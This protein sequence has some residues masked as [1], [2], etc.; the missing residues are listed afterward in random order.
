ML[1]IP[2]G[3]KPDLQHFPY[4]TVILV[5]LNCLVFFGFQLKEQQAA[6]QAGA[7]Y[8]QQGLQDIECP[9]YLTYLNQ[10]GQA[11]KAGK[12]AAML[13]KKDV[14]ILAVMQND[15]DYLKAMHGDQIVKENEQV[16]YDWK[17][18][19]A[20]FELRL[21][22]RFTD[23]YAL[24]SRELKP[25]TFLS[26]MFMHANTG[27]LLGNMLVLLLV[28]YIV[29]DVLGG[30]RFLCFYLISGAGAGA[31]FIAASTGHDAGLLGASGAIAGVMGMYAALFGFRKIEFFYWILIYC[32]LARLPAIVLLPVWLANEIYQKLTT[33]DSNVAY[34]AHVG[35]LLVGALL[36]YLGRMQGVVNVDAMFAEEKPENDY[37]QELK[38]ADALLEKLEVDRAVQA[39]FALLGKYPESLEL[40]NKI[41]AICKNQ[42]LSREY[43]RL[44]QRI[45]A[46]SSREEAIVA[47]Q[48]KMYPL[49]A[50]TKDFMLQNQPLE[51]LGGFIAFQHLRQ[52]EHL[53]DKLLH[54]GVRDPK[55]PAL[56]VAL[57]KQQRAADML[58]QARKNA[59]RL[60]QLFPDSREAQKL[61]AV[62]N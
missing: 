29:E 6:E 48:A 56:L 13:E 35:G 8:F 19:R 43:Q 1:I 7:Y 3:H 23:E 2:I 50:D 32:D 11:E 54:N 60:L 45:F 16:Y 58:E 37:R 41:Y 59:G 57:V 47:M 22:S 38:K 28:G 55:L 5:L 27:H 52:A 26:H 20:E 49:V 21:G 44:A 53:L 17:L 62:K 15:R 4:V 40:I 46:L 31:V 42:P 30:L 39:Y 34:M 51:L 61:K 25:I 10:H 9:R 33:T 18:K 36:I 12:V 24:D 14:A